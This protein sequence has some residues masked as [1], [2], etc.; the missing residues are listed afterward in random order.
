M[1]L[2]LWLG[3][4]WWIIYCPNK[5]Q[6]VVKGVIPKILMLVNSNSEYLIVFLPAYYTSL[7]KIGSFIRLSTIFPLF[8]FYPFLHF[9]TYSN[10]VN[11]LS[12]EFSSVNL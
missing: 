8:F 11:K 7:L 3:C 5:R 6:S 9:F 4:C 12:V 2:N 10:Q 1:G